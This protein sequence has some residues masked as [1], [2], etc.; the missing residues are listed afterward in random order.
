MGVKITVKRVISFKQSRW[1]ADYTSD[2]SKLRT[3]ANNNKN[4]FLASLFK[5]M[6]NSIL[7]EHAFSH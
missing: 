7:G 3:E 6:N 1:M 5:L 4:E 2:N